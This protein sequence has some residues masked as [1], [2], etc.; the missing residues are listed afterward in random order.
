[1]TVAHRFLE[2]CS[3]HLAKVNAAGLTTAIRKV[4]GSSLSRKINL[5]GQLVTNFCSLNYMGY[6][7]DERVISAMLENVQKYGTGLASSR[8]VLD[9]EQH[10][11]FED[12]LA[13]F[14]RS[15]GCKLINTG[16]NASYGIMEILCKSPN[17]FGVRS[18]LP[19]AHVFYDALVH[20]SIRESL[21]NNQINSTAYKHLNY[22]NLEDRI[23]K[24]KEDEI[25]K[26]IVTDSIFSMH[27]GIADVKKLLEIAKKYDA[28]LILDNAH[29]DG[30][31]GR[32]GRGI[33]EMQGITSEEDLKYIFNAGTLSKTFSQMG[34]FITLPKDFSDVVPLSHYGYI[35]SVALPTFQVATLRTV[36]AMIIGE[37]GDRRRRKLHDTSEFLR[38][39]LKEKGFD[40]GNSV[41]HIAPVMVGDEGVCKRAEHSLVEK[42]I[43]VKAIHWP[44]VKKGGALLRLALTANHD[45]EDVEHLTESLVRVRDKLRF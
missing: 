33:A 5:N 4:S 29:S 35:F 37:D 36:L 9:S 21:G 15:S 30:I 14:K 7:D 20:A 8:T 10:C 13:L 42:G 38:H 22:D 2:F 45:F 40:I 28:L 44:A 3:D 27:G 24:N 19:R 26:F 23:S 18:G 32:E 43:F 25:T 39:T 6:G 41:S 12:E 16:Y 34:G 17:S 11:L 31:Y 1:M